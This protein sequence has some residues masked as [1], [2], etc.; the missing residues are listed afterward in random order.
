MLSQNYTGN[1]ARNLI[2]P[3]SFYTDLQAVADIQ[4]DGMSLN[5]GHLAAVVVFQDV[6]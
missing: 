5:P 1:F 3:I 2:F 6:L 4:R